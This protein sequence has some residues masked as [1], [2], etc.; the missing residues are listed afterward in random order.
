MSFKNIGKRETLPDRV[1]RTIKESILNGEIC[2]G[3]ALPTEPELEKQF[4]VSRAVIRDAVRM[5]KAQGLIEVRHGKGMY[6]TKPQIESFMDSLLTTL[7]RDQANAWDSEEFEQIFLPQVFTLAAQTANSQE[8]KHI[9]KL[10]EQYLS[11]F[12]TLI[13]FEIEGDK[14]KITKQEIETHNVFNDFMLSVFEATGNKMIKL[15]GQVS[16]SIRKFR[17]I[18]DL[19]PDDTRIYKLEKIAIETYIKAVESTNGEDSAKL[20]S[21]ILTYGGEMKKIMKETPIGQSPQIP[22]DIFFSSYDI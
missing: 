17:Q 15:L 21:S 3:D 4:G 11:V 8:K 16:L 13:D 5:L 1:S 2:G 12:K 14:E 10:G 9:R 20:I 19:K 18:T 7:R 6:V 22:S